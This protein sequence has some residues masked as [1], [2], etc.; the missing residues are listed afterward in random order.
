MDFVPSQFSTSCHNMNLLPLS[1][2]EDKQHLALA[3][4]QTVA[5]FLV[6]VLAK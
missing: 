3:Y 6:L 5:G 1:A 4:A 2:D